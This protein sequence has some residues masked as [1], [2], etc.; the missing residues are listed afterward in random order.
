VR[1]RLDEISY[2]IRFTPRK[3]TSTWSAVNIKRVAELTAL[4]R[5]QPAGLAAFARRSEK[6][7]EVYS[8]E[9]KAL[10]FDDA[11]LAAFRTH[12]AAW[13]HF[14]AQ[15][16]FYK[17]A[18]SQWIMSAKRP[19]T[20]ERRLGAVIAASKKGIRVDLTAPFAHLVED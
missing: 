9:R 11:V 16:P 10:T 12:K 17:R 15:A 20:R 8:F 14:D 19:E 7:S 6:R 18:L 1:R 4:G 3:P 5:M 13:A 2:T